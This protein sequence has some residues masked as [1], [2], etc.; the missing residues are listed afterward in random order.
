MKVFWENFNGE[1]FET[2][3]LNAEIFY[4]F[5]VLLE[6]IGASKFQYVVKFLFF[7]YFGNFKMFSFY[8]LIY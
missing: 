5:T 6:T 8:E 3:N 7:F 2:L 4:R 1:K